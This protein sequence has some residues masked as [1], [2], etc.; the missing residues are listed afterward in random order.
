MA[1]TD[2]K[3]T[4]VAMHQALKCMGHESKAISVLPSA[5]LQIIY[6]VENTFHNVDVQNYIWVYSLFP[7]LM[8]KTHLLK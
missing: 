7:T 3:F 6:F 4:H 8:Q 1:V 2:I 5:R